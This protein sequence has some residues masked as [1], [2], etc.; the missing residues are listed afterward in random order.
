VANGL[1]LVLRYS[2]ADIS[3]TAKVHEDNRAL[4]KAYVDRYPE[5]R[6]AFVSVVARAVEP[7]GR[8][9]GSLMAMKDV[10]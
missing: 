5:Y 2:A 6:E 8:D 9:F 4:I 1:S 3:N 7:S 10:K